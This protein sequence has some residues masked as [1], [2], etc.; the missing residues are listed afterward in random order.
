MAEYRGLTIRI[1]AD[2]GSLTASIRAAQSAM[3]A[4]EK[5]ARQLARALVMDPGNKNAGAIYVGELQSQAVAAVAKLRGL[6]QEMDEIGS[7][8]LK[9][10]WGGTISQL[11]EQ[12]DDAAL[13]AR[14]AKEAYNEVTSSLTE[15]YDALTALSYEAFEEDY[16]IFNHEHNNMDDIINEYEEI[17]KTRPDLISEEDAQNAIARIQ[18][19]KTNF[20]KL[21]D[22]YDDAVLVE[23]L[24][25]DEVAAAALEAKIHALSERMADATQS[26][27]S[28]SLEEDA[29]AAERLAKG[30]EL[31]Q[32]EA[33]ERR[34]TL[35]I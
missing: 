30:V 2:T 7:T 12:T 18:D 29:R 20:Q 5:Q 19:L 32:R 25:N 31:A 14:R 27:L 1:G 26:D 34:Q 10:A 28:R 24:H 33:C 17:A 9:V 22:A 11:A 3:S 4:A 6:K 15:M 35:G 13:K 23:N 8:E 16:N 21:S